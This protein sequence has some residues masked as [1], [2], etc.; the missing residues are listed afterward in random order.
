MTYSNNYVKMSTFKFIINAIRVCA[1]VLL[2]PIISLF[3]LICFTSCN[4]VLCISIA[5]CGDDDFSS[6][7]MDLTIRLCSLQV[8]L[9]TSSKA[10]ILAVKVA[11]RA[12]CIKSANTIVLGVVV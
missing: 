10:T 3:V 8:V 6:R 11:H 4:R 2:L 1:F 5:T 9:H 7:G 12:E